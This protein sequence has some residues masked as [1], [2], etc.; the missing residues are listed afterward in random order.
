[1]GS[2]FSRLL[3][4]ELHRL[5]RTTYLN[6]HMNSHKVVANVVMVFA[7]KFSLS[8]DLSSLVLATTEGTDK[9]PKILE[10]DGS[11]KAF[12]LETLQINKSELNA[13]RVA[14]DDLYARLDID[15]ML[16]KTF[17]QQNKQCDKITNEEQEQ[18]GAGDEAF[19][20]VLVSA[21]CQEHYLNMNMMERISLAH[22]RL[23]FSE[24][25]RLMGDGLDFD[26]LPG[27]MIMENKEA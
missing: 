10:D 19:P 21:G 13:N 8:S 5:V 1:M 20:G 11:K 16:L 23:S 22:A 3:W 9:G 4:E 18:S 24:F 27:S 12:I 2:S 7:S 14:V 15:R 6:P 25:Y 17:I 26:D